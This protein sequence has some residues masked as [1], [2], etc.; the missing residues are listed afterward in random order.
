MLQIFADSMMVA[1]RMDGWSGAPRLRP[2][3]PRP[4]A[5]ED[6]S[7]PRSG[8]LRLGGLLR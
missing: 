2:A 8:W 7:E 5:Q 1:T 4:D 6:A 3:R